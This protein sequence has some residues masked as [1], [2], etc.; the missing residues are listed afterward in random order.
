M[1]A[2]ADIIQRELLSFSGITG[3]KGN[4]VFNVPVPQLQKI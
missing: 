2:I 3:W 1:Y 4:V